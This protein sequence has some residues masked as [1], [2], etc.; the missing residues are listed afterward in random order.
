MG[1]GG[2]T[3]DRSTGGRTR[4]TA[5]VSSSAVPGG[6]PLHRRWWHVILPVH[7][8]RRCSHGRHRGVGHQRPCRTDRRTR[9]Q[10]SQMPI[11]WR[12]VRG[13]SRMGGGGRRG[14]RVRGVRVMLGSMGVGRKVKRIERRGGVLTHLTQV[15]GSE[16]VGWGGM[17][18]CGMRTAVGNVG[19]GRG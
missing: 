2:R 11:G 8:R 17:R 5:S 7:Q 19:G 12:D 6:R 4:G 18:R 10:P 16:E 1:S 14:S 3:R 9:E 13:T 15:G